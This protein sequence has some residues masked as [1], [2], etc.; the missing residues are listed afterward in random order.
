MSDDEYAPPLPW[1]LNALDG[2]F[3]EFARDACAAILADP[4]FSTLKDIDAGDFPYL[5]WRYWEEVATGALGIVVRRHN[6]PVGPGSPDIPPS[7]MLLSWVAEH[8]RLIRT[9][10]DNHGRVQFDAP[11]WRLADL[12]QRAVRIGV[13]AERAFGAQTSEAATSAV[14]RFMSGIQPKSV[15][16]RTPWRPVARDA[17]RGEMRRRPRLTNDAAAEWLLLEA[18]DEIK[19]ALRAKGVPGVTQVSEWIGAERR[20][21]KGQDL[22]EG[23]PPK[24]VQT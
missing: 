5:E 16:A 18:P 7:I 4:M 20:N 3:D 1:T 24:G 14:S 13:M 11:A 8:E 17:L 19:A 22:T 23:L 6:G 9:G 10:R 12:A 15:E 21:W 2:I